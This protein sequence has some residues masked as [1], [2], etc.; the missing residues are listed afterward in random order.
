[1]TKDHQN[2]H[3]SAGDMEDDVVFEEEASDVSGFKSKSDGKLRKELKQAQKEAR[4]YLEGWQRTKADLIN[5][6]RESEHTRQQTA[7]YAAS[8]LIMQL[9]PVVDSFEMAL[10]H[11]DDE[12]V[13]H[14]YNQLLGVLKQ[15]G[16]VQD[17]PEGEHFDP[18]RHDSIEQVQ[19]EN[20]N[21]DNTI[22][23]VVQKGYTLHNK[24]LRPARV[25]VGTYES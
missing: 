22:V 14:I 4:E 18:N 3:T 21:K 17:N 6:K 10:T 11:V 24:I 7:Q 16:V 20:K 2:N 23:E 13:R 8:D 19:V 1:M 15:N 12:G 9:L 5:F 25:K